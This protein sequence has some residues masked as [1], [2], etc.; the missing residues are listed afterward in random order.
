ML[1]WAGA[2]SMA[3]LH[4]RH[5]GALEGLR[6]RRFQL[7]RFPAVKRVEMLEELREQA[8]AE[9]VHMPAR[10]VAGFVLIKAQVGV[11]RGLAN[12]KT[13]SAHA[14]SILQERDIERMMR[15]SGADGRRAQLPCRVLGLRHP[16]WQ[17][18]HTRIV[19]RSHTEFGDLRPSRQCIAPRQPVPMEPTPT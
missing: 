9:P 18:E 8:D 3:T 16:F 4:P 7:D 19:P 17:G 6:Q 1:C 10:L 2:G 14:A 15:T 13:P 11:E 12:I 5:A